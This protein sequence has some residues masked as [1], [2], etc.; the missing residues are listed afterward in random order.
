MG[1]WGEKGYDNDS[2]CDW[3]GGLSDTLRFIFDHAF[4]SRWEEEGIA[5]A[6]LLSELPATLQDRLGVFVFNEALEV[7]DHQLE[8]EMVSP[9]K[10]PAKR[11][12]Y[13][14]SLRR[15][16]SLRQKVLDREEKSTRARM[17]LVFKKMKG[18]KKADRNPK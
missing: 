10:F 15:K 13:L 8:P 5:A 17:K 14:V 6:Q 9:Y 2:A 12:G 1:A 11:R 3:L 7:V 18:T 16:L 4:Y